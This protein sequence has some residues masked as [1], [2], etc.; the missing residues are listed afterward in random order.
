MI[1]FACGACSE[2]R[3]RLTKLCVQGHYEAAAAFQKLEELDYEA[4]QALA[5]SFEMSKAAMLLRFTQG[6]KFYEQYPWNLP[7]LLEF[8]LTADNVR[9]AAVERSR[10]FAGQLVEWKENNALPKDTF[11]DCVLLNPGLFGALKSWASSQ[12]GL[13]NVKLFRKLLEYS[14]FFFR[15][16][17]LSQNTTWCTNGKRPLGQG[18]WQCQL[19]E[20]TEL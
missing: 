14:L 20:K 4:A 17:G 12:D 7:K 18:V 2:F 1:E 13:M 8:I 11:G 16:N 3:G 19:A 5:R 9:S 15:C 10:H 6:S